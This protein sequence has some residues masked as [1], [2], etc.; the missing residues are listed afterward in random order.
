MH[1]TRLAVKGFRSLKDV[2][3][4]P[5]KLNVLIGP[6]G[7]GKT[8]LLK[9][10]E[11]LSASAQGELSRYVQ[12][13]G[14][15]EPLVWDGGANRI[16]VDC[17]C[18]SWDDGVILTFYYKLGISR[19]AGTANYVIL[20][21]SLSG[22][23]RNRS[24]DPKPCLL[25]DQRVGEGSF[26]SG[27][28]EVKTLSHDILNSKETSLSMLSG[29]APLTHHFISGLK[30]WTTFD[31]NTR[32]MREPALVSRER[33]VDPG[34]ENFIA[35]LHTAYSSDRDFK[36][37]I[38]LAM[39]A[40]FGD[41]FEE[42]T[43]PPAE[44]RR[45]QLR[46]RWRSLKH[47]QSAADL[48]D[49]TLRFLFLLTVLA[50]PTRPGVIAVE[51]PENG[52]H[53]SM[54][55]IIAEFAAEASRTSQVIFTTHSQT[56][57]DAIGKQDV[58]VTVAESAAGETKLKNLSGDALKYWL[59]EFTLGEVYRTGQLESWVKKF[60]LLVEGTT[61]GKSLPS[62][63]KR[64]LDPRLKSSIG[65]RTLAVGGWSKLT[66]RRRSELSNPQNVDA[67]AVV[68]LL[69]LY[70]PRHEKGPVC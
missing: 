54:L 26:L 66:P 23:D 33:H 43:F 21:E 32:L 46:V 52:L 10:L 20:H 50:M 64:W 4:T 69:D 67:I 49:G 37:E 31:G 25:L 48:S 55:P 45:I 5:G 47:E 39:K 36:R 11:M 3:W 18:E 34:G 40:A 60:V 62:F 68:A 19:L 8:N 6:N 56:F 65:R 27:S 38:N 22:I 28:E 2:V 7:G 42:L 53:P 63:L 29:V 9:A 35:A 15:M 12:R 44:D 1:I 41:E 16:E 61:E 59:D 24:E 57:L 14:G 58:T 17:E 13:E 51:E 70:G 30:S